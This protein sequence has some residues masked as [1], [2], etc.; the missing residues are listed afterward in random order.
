V[1]TD[2]L[3]IVVTAPAAASPLE[4][5]GM[6]RRLEEAVAD[7]ISD[8]ATR[9][10]LTH[11][12]VDPGDVQL[13]IAASHLASPE[14]LAAVGDAVTAVLD[15]PDALGWGPFTLDVTQESQDPESGPDPL[16]GMVRHLRAVPDGEDSRPSGPAGHPP[17]PVFDPEPARQRLRADADHLRDGLPPQWL[18][19]RDIHATDPD[20]REAAFTEARYV[21]GALYQAAVITIDYLFSD[22]A[23]L[24]GSRDHTATVATAESAAFFVLEDL[25]TRY[26]HRYDVLFVKRFI[27]ATVTVTQR[28][29][30]GWDPL[31]CVAEELALRI[32]LDEAEAR[33]DEAGL[34]IPNWRATIEDYLFEDA[35]H[36][37]L[38]NPSLDGIENDEDFLART[39]TAPMAFPEWFTPFNDERPIPPYLLDNSRR[40]RPGK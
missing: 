16:D 18:T 25:P 31:A 20:E 12:S 4:R 11:G 5:D 8:I 29:T 21:A 37:M 40:K 1:D 36:E 10:Y 35:D 39:R 17:V 14:A 15:A 24:T 23:Q 26:A 19:A 32:V 34:D 3:T 33:L 27:V 6:L 7:A 22:L 13:Q 28:L 9:G 30:A 2:E 38:F